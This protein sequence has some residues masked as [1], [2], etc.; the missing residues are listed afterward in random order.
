LRLDG[1]NYRFIAGEQVLVL[2]DHI[3]RVGA[4]NLRNIQTEALD[5]GAT[6]FQKSSHPRVTWN[7][8]CTSPEQLDGILIQPNVHEWFSYVSASDTFQ[9]IYIDQKIQI[10]D[11][12]CKSIS[13]KM[14]KDSK[15]QKWDIWQ[16]EGFYEVE[17]LHSYEVELQL[18]PE[19]SRE[20][21]FVDGVFKEPEVI[22]STL[23]AFEKKRIPYQY[24]L[25]RPTA[26]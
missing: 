20:I 14:F 7:Y 6:T 17:N 26:D 18:T 12:L 16:F 22:R 8:P 2:R 10:T 9:L 19:K 3:V 15:K 21:Y 1:Q 13:Q 24:R 11:S 4:D 25:M 23:K 5:W